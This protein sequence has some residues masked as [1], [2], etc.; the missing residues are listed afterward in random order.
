MSAKGFQKIV[1]NAFDYCDLYIFTM[2]LLLAEEKGKNFLFRTAVDFVK[3]RGGVGDRP[4][5]A[6]EELVRE[7]GNGGLILVGSHVANPAFEFIYRIVSL[8]FIQITEV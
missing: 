2:G 1:V 4:L 3:V 5:L 8:I 6:R 7:N